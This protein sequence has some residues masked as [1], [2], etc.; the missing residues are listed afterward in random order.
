MN[1][2]TEEERLRALEKVKKQF[3]ERDI[4]GFV[5]GRLAGPASPDRPNVPI[6]EYPAFLSEHPELSMNDLLHVRFPEI[7]EDGFNSVSSLRDHLGRT[8]DSDRID[9]LSPEDIIR[10]YRLNFE[11]GALRWNSETRSVEHTERMRTHQRTVLNKWMSEMHRRRTG[12][13]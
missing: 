5:V 1:E 3:P 8:S 4:E 2:F 12:Q 10:L 9:P 7:F 6:W 11:A 13:T